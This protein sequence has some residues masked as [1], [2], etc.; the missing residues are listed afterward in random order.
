[1]VTG[2]ILRRVIAEQ[3]LEKD[4]AGFGVDMLGIAQAMAF[5]PDLPNQWRD[6]E[7]EIKL[8]QVNWKNKTLAAL[9]VMAVT[10]A[11]LKR[12]AQGKSPKS[13]VSPFFSLIGDQIETNKRT[14]RYKRWRKNTA[15]AV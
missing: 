5:R 11:Q 14:Q 1:M 4:S 9:A 6:H 12:V 13:N 2:G 10:K 15:Q 3:A 7:L 8:P